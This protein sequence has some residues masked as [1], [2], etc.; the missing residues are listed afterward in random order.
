[1]RTLVYSRLTYRF[2][3]R[4]S[5]FLSS[6]AISGLGFSTGSVLFGSADVGTG[7]WAAGLAAGVAPGTILVPT[8][9]FT[10]AT[11]LP[12]QILQLG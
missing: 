1:M 6:F 10:P 12:E 4:P 5:S 2:P 3:S 11:G 9:G 7:P 8:A